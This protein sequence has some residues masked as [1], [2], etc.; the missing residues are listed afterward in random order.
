MEAN[1]RCGAHKLVAL[2]LAPPL[3]CGDPTEWAI[4][5]A[6]TPAQFFLLL[7]HGSEMLFGLWFLV[8]TGMSYVPAKL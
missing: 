4:P 8:Y 7:S 5:S 3:Q 2:W 6:F 1:R